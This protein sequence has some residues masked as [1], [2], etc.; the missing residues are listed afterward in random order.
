M[1]K[2]EIVLSLIDK[3]LNSSDSDN[4]RDSEK[5]ESVFIWK[6][7]ILRCR[8]AWVHFWKLEH[9]KGWVYRLAESRRLYYWNNNQWVT[10]SETALFWLKDNSKICATLDL[11]EITEKE[12]A[13]I[14]PCVQIAIDSIK[15]KKDYIS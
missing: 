15:S 14:I 10:L 4:K 9:A 1:N 11:I 8:N 3:L 5:S 6:Y 13:E 12:G 2:E 7:V